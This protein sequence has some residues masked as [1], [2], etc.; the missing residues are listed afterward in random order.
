MQSHKGGRKDAF[1]KSTHLLKLRER[2]GKRSHSPRG[3]LKE[4]REREKV[5]EPTQVRRERK[6]GGGV[7]EQGRKQRQKKK[8]KT[9][10]DALGRRRGGTK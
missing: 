1:V 9:I 4:E 8:K 7:L 5:K 3:T 10:R 6:E 2:K